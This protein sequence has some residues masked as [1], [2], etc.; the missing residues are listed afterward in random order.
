M[1]EIDPSGIA[2]GDSGRRR[3]LNW[4]LGTGFGATLV[5]VFYPVIRFLNPPEIPEA[6]VSRVLAGTI[7]ELPLNSAKVFKFGT[8]PAILLRTA[9]G[10]FRAF[11]A[12][13][14]HLD[15]TVQYRSDRNQFWCAC[16]NGF[17]DQNGKNVSGPPPRPLETFSVKILDDEIYVSR[18]G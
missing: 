17:Y 6:Q 8:S 10:E 13:C 3:F 2:A 9:D 4:F 7:E 1:N 14:T 15:C 16:H 12:T 5:A 18:Q 11:T